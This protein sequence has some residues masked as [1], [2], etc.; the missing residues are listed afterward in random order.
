MI[1][2]TIKERLAVLE[3]TELE[4]IN[5]SALHQG[6]PAYENAVVE[7][8]SHFFARIVSAKFAELSQVEQHRLVYNLLAKEMVDHIHALRLETVIPS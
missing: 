6:H 8:E 7:G 3:P 2:D 5:E 4:I 1:I